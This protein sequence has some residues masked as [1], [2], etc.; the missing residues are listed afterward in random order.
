M[1]DDSQLRHRRN[2]PSPNVGGGG[3]V[4]ATSGDNSNSN[5]N[6][7]SILPIHDA[8]PMTQ[9]QKRIYKGQK[10]RKRKRLL[11][12]TMYNLRQ[13]ATTCLAGVGATLVSGT[14]SVLLLPTAWFQV[15]YHHQVQH[16]AT[17]V[18]QQVRRKRLR[19]RNLGSDLH[20]G[21]G[22]AIGNARED[23]FGGEALPNDNNN[24]GSNDLI[25][26][27]AVTCPD[28]TTG[29]TNDDYCDCIDDGSDETTT[30]ACSHRLVQIPTFHCLDGELVIY[31]SRVQDGVADCSDGSDEL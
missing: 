24:G 27:S 14:L 23:G 25:M 16:A 22:A 20:T 4:G 31:A 26:P 30:S 8:P 28:G 13:L 3:P 12:F 10:K 1:F 7:D 29:F 5:S 17:Q 21:S 19:S 15:D 11:A 6:H 18:Y 9:K 2:Q